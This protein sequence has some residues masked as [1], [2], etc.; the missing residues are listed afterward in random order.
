MLWTAAVQHVQFAHCPT[1]A[2]FPFS[3]SSYILFAS[4]FNG[5]VF[6]HTA[7]KCETYLDKKISVSR[8]RY[9]IIRI[10]TRSIMVARTTAP[11]RTNACP[12]CSTSRDRLTGRAH[13]ERTR[14]LMGGYKSSAYLGSDPLPPL[15]ELY[16]WAKCETGF[17]KQVS[18]DVCVVIKVCE[19]RECFTAL[20]RRGHVDSINVRLTTGSR[21]TLGTSVAFTHAVP[22]CGFSP[23]AHH[24]V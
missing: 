11:R 14:I 1:D 21:G 4:S 2:V 16:I 22:H 13:C 15:R 10:D 12:A 7:N 5:V 18:L 8:V 17:S 9:G 3:R 19:T 20:E 24:S 23:V 6:W